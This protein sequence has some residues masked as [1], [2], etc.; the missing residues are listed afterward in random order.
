M[1]IQVID[2][3]IIRSDI[4]ATYCKNNSEPKTSLLS[5]P[6]LKQRTGQKFVIEEN[7][8]GDGKV[9]YMY[10]LWSM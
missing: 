1:Y 2:E 8:S 10:I 9:T 5:F 6:K 3:N 7:N 4:K